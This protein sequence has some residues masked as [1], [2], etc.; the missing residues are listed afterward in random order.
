M[1]KRVTTQTDIKDKGLAIAAL[2]SAGLAFQE[3]GNTLRI[4][5]GPLANAT[6]DLGS[7]LISGDTDFGHRKESMGILRQHYSE[8]QFRKEATKA[9][10]SIGQRLVEKQSGDVILKCRMA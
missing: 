8:A 4:T 7:G 6:I 5:S 10:V 1:S 9:G 2:T 3:M